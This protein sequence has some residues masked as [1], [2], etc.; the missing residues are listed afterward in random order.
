[1]VIVQIKY[2]G[3]LMV[4]WP[5]CRYLCKV[6]PQYIRS[7]VSLEVFNDNFYSAATIRYGQQLTDGTP[8]KLWVTDTYI[9]SYMMMLPAISISCLFPFFPLNLCNTALTNRSP[10][11]VA[12]YTYVCSTLVVN[13]MLILCFN[14]IHVH[15]CYVN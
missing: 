5:H 12:A 11:C 1:M 14:I 8:S 13:C 10:I 6:I 4:K 15:A 2:E 9:L 3:N 7:W